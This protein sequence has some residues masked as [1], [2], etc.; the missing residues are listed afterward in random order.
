MAV[1]VELGEHALVAKR[2][3]HHP[4]GPRHVERFQPLGLDPLENL[5][6]DRLGRFTFQNDDHCKSPWNRERGK[7]K[8]AGLRRVQETFGREELSS[9]YPIAGRAASGAGNQR[10]QFVAEFSVFIVLNMRCGCGSVNRLIRDRVRG[11]P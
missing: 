10:H 1:E 6:G 7:K 4:L 8:P 11:W 5:V 9:G 3:Q 2:A